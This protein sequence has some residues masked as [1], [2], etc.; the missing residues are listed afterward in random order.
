MVTFVSQT[1]ETPSVPA[2]FF[3]CRIYFYVCALCIVFFSAVVASLVPHVD[4]FC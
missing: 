3:F 1:L 2:G 4:V